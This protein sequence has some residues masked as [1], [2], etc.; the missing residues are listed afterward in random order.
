MKWT[1][2]ELK[3][4]QSIEI[5]ELVDLSKVKERDK[6]IRDISPVKVTGLGKVSGDAYTFTLKIE[7]TLTLP[8]SRTLEDVQLPF[9]IET[10]EVFLEHANEWDEEE[11]NQDNVH[12]IDG[13]TI[14]LVPH[15]KEH[16]LLEIPL[17]I[18]SD[19]V[20][21]EL[22]KGEDWQLLTEETKHNRIDPRLADL[23]KFFDKN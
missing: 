10:K 4:K 17:Q 9:Q 20:T 11:D 2:Q 12:V 14:D 16:I 5:N 6:Q 1:T 15:I 22:P 8:C 7:G 3:K 23:Q 21:D 19:K 13:E 18:F